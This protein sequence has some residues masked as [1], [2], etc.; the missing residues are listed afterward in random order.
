MLK[1]LNFTSDSQL[2]V[3]LQIKR[4]VVQNQSQLKHT[5]FGMASQTT[6]TSAVLAFSTRTFFFI[7][8]SCFN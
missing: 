8:S 2:Y 3:Y 7:D 1:I 4:L 5:S 6:V